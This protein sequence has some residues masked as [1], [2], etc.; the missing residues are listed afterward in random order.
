MDLDRHVWTSV[1]MRL[2]LGS[3]FIFAGVLKLFFDVAPPI[4][5]IIFFMPKE[6]SVALLGILEFV[7]GVLLLIGLLARAASV[8]AALLLAG[9]VFSSF[10]LGV[11]VTQF[12]IKDI[13][14]FAV[15]LHVALHGAPVFSADNLVQRL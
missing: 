15:A 10:A 5:K 14:L 2:T 9:F 3:V 11:F 12:I 8:V 7:V 13:V 1:L 6:T 4:E